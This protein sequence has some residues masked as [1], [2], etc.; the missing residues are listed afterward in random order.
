MHIGVGKHALRNLRQKNFGLAGGQLNT[1]KIHVQKVFYSSGSLNSKR[2]CALVSWLSE[3]CWRQDSR[4]WCKKHATIWPNCHS[5]Q[6][7]LTGTA[8]SFWYFERV[9]LLNTG[10]NTDADHHHNC[11][12]QTFVWISI[13]MTGRGMTLDS[14]EVSVRRARKKM[15]EMRK[16]VF[17][18]E[19]LHHESRMMKFNDTF[20]QS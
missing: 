7:L 5:C 6:S 10:L 12:T 17:R 3:L 13:C 1:L 19:C 9:F 4:R 14:D 18:S 20:L 8:K 15:R 11:Q 16:R 2:S